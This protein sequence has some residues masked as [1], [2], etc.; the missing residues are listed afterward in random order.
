MQD[1]GSTLLMGMVTEYS[2]QRFAIDYNPGAAVLSPSDLPARGFD[3]SL[4]NLHSSRDTAADW[5]SFIR[6]IASVAMDWKHKPIAPIVRVKTVR[7]TGF[8]EQIHTRS[9]PDCT[10]GYSWDWKR[11]LLTCY[12]SMRWSYCG[13]G[14]NTTAYLDTDAVAQGQSCSRY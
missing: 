9:T 5:I 14:I 13:Q 6:T 10:A 4:H 8:A 12:D 3:V 11:S 7:G 1:V 2:C